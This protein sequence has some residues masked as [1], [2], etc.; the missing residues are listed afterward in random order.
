MT[1]PATVTPIESDAELLLRIQ[2]A[3]ATID[4]ATRNKKNSEAELLA[5]RK[6]EITTLLKT[7][8]EPYGKVDIIVGNHKVAVT[9]PKKI[10]YDQSLLKQKVRQLIDANENP[11]L[12][13]KTEYDISETRWKEFP[14]DVQ[15][16]LGEART[17]KPGSVSLKIVEEKV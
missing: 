9:T 7:K 5:R 12:Y 14:V 1:Q 3:Q 10:E 15:K 17:V 2:Q 6:D 8:D 4:V 13:I 16:W 11:D